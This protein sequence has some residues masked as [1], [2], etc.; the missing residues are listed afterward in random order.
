MINL[1]NILSGKLQKKLKIPDPQ[2]H[3]IKMENGNWSRSNLQMADLFSK[4]LVKTFTPNDSSDAD[5]LIYD[6]ILENGELSACTRSELNKLIARLKPK[7][8][9]GFDL[10][11]L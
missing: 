3:S 7:K 2:S 10:R 6:N 9:P 1:L 5:L 8:A 4:H 11:Y